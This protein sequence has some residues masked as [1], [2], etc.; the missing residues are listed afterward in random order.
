MP[1]A[2]VVARLDIAGLVRTGSEMVGPCPICGGKDRFG[3]NL[4]SGV[5]QCR[6]DCGP[7][8]KGD[9]VALVQHVL[10]I[11]FRAA[12]DWLCGPAVGISDAERAERRKR[13]EE[14]RRRQDD[15]ARRRREDSISAARKIWADALP[16]EGTVV[17]DYLTLRGIDPGRLA[18]LPVT[19][20]FAP[21]A[22]Y[23]IPADGRPGKWDIIHT[24]PAMV[25]AMVDPAGYTTSVHRTWLDLSQPKG[26]LVL[27]DP[28]K[29]G[30]VLPAKKVL[31]SKKGASI[32]FLT[33]T[34]CDTMVMG[35]G[36]E[37]SL[38]ALIAEDPPRRTAYW[39]GVDLGNMAGRQQRGPGMKYAGLPDLDDADAW[40][41]PAWV[42]RLI[43]I[44]DGDSDRRLT[45][46]KLE[47]GLRR[48]MLRRPGLTGAIVHPGEGM[49]LNDILM[50]GSGD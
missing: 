8:A 35:E 15:I 19:I 14:N 2:D 17:R 11:D 24:G 41:P 22:R 42:R 28:R 5:F 18:N 34:G 30:E 20:R 10:G 27:P 6:R 26:K 29:P 13:A 16:A 46:A 3:I 39:C 37:T 1:I 45:R 44:Q 4:Q 36:V 38:S 43:F 31:G 48:A 7:H 40:V 33:P 49:D 47:A 9:Q 25:C 21:A 50:D 23:T 12:L 32:R